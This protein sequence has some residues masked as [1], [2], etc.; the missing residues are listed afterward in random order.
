MD[1]ANMSSGI[2]TFASEDVI[3]DSDDEEG[4][5]SRPKVIADSEDDEIEEPRPK[6]RRK[7]QSMAWRRSL[8]KQETLTQMDF[9]TRPGNG[10]EDEDTRHPTTDEAEVEP[11]FSMPDVIRKDEVRA[12]GH[13]SW[14]PEKVKTT[15]RSDDELAHCNRVIPDSEDP[16]SLEMEIT[17]PSPTTPHPQTPT[18]VVRVLEV[19]SSQTPHTTPIS[20]HSIYTQARQ[21]QLDPPTPSK[22]P[23]VARS[24]PSN[25]VTL[26]GE[27]VRQT[28]LRHSKEVQSSPIATVVVI[29][30]DTDGYTDS[31][32]TAIIDIPSAK[33]DRQ[34]TTIPLNDV[35]KSPS[36]EVSIWTRQSQGLK[37]QQRNQSQI[38]RHNARTQSSMRKAFEQLPFTMPETQSQ[39]TQTSPGT[40]RRVAEFNAIWA[41]LD[42]PVRPRIPQPDWN[43]RVG[44]GNLEP[45]NNGRLKMPYALGDETQLALM[46]MGM[47]DDD[48]EMFSPDRL[49]PE[50]PPKNH[51][52]VPGTL[53][54]EGWFE[55]PLG[56]GGGDEDSDLPGDPSRVVV[57]TQD[58][59]EQAQDNNNIIHGSSQVRYEGDRVLETQEEE[60]PG[61][62]EYPI[63]P[64]QAST[65]PGTPKSQRKMSQQALVQFRNTVGKEV[66]VISSSPVPRRLWMPLRETEQ[67]TK[68]NEEEEESQ[69]LPEYPDSCEN[70]VVAGNFHDEGGRR[71]PAGISQLL[72]SS[73]MNDLPLPP[74]S[75][76]MDI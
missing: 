38:S 12:K 41:E 76:E 46:E 17:E 28:Q 69:G 66:I 72:P 55:I 11:V 19:P 64:S 13:E 20:I 9:L 51:I 24:S 59:N 29:A 15:E 32:D 25:H 57:E 27:G 1:F 63:R 65:V 44:T 2:K 23:S 49:G 40:R 42:K 68:E 54:S 53:K 34:P 62:D 56:G 26:D 73:I 22:L 36:C 47:D 31:E 61:D 67:D 30:D 33:L 21:P 60:E 75:S 8:V 4:R 7:V 37:S 52:T 10:L 48:M 14:S 18:R 45:Q 71:R 74:Q 16:L 70:T 43:R 5:R 58:A 39:I 6:K 35:Q 50:P 3:A